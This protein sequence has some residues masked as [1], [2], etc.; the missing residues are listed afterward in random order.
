MERRCR[1]HQQRRTSAGNP[2]TRFA[3]AGGFASLP[4]DSFANDSLRRFVPR[5]GTIVVNNAGVVNVST[6]SGL[7]RPSS[8]RPCGEQAWTELIV[9]RKKKCG[10]LT[11]IN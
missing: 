7:R 1:S 6:T 2:A 3:R 8:G 10:K 9:A 11:V 4:Y 5:L